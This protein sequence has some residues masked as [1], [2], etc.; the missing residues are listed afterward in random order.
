MRRRRQETLWI[1]KW[2]RPMIGAI[3]AVGAAG[4]GYLTFMRLTSGDAACGSGCGKVLSSAWATILGQP[5]TLFGCLAYLSMLALAVAPLVVSPENN[6]DLRVKL[7]GLT[8][9][10]LFVGATGMM[11]FS[12]FLMYVLATKIQAVCPYC[13]GSALF[14]VTMFV[15]TLLGRRWDDRGQLLF[16]GAIIAMVSLVATLGVYAAPGGPLSAQSTGDPV[17]GNGVTAPITNPS[18]ASEVALAKHLTEIDAKMYGAYWCP[19]CFDQKQLFGR[20]AAKQIPYIECAPDGQKSQT[21]LC[22]SVPGVTGFPTWEVNGEF[23]SGSQSLETLAEASGYDG[24]TD[25][26]NSAGGVGGS[27]SGG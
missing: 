10:L 24:P 11:I 26:I 8:W 7:E 19:H 2:S 5:L 16:S 3:A 20:D 9:P 15:L 4:T 6:K 21:A 18:S 23:L 17:P 1:H 25:F 13:I 27:S 14:T 12:A 22:Q